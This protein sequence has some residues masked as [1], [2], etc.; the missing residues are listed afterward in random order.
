MAKESTLQDK[1][2]KWLRSQKCIV[3]KYQQNA[4]TR[5]GVPH[6]VQARK[7]W[8]R[9]WTIGVGL[10]WCIPLTGQKYKKK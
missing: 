7:L 8:L 4:T 9:R 6:S 1:I 5:A 2:I 10:K 3:L